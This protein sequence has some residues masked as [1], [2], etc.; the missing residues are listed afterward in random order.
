V[1]V[2]VNG[3]TAVEA[4]E[5]FFVNLSTP[6]N[7]TINDAQATGT[8]QNDDTAPSEPPAVSI[9]DVSHPEGNSGTT[10][11]AFTVSLSHVATG[12][13]SVP[14]ST[15][16]GSAT[17]PSDYTATS[18]T[19][20]FAAGETSKT[21]TVLANGDTGYENDETFTVNLGEPT[22]ATIAD[23]Q[24]TGTI[25]NDDAP[26]SISVDDVSHSEGNSGTTA[27]TFTVSL[28]SPS[29][30]AVTVS[31]ATADG[32]AAAGSDYTTTSGTLT[33]APGEQVKQV[34]VTASGDTL[35]EVNET[36]TLNLSS[37]T[38]GVIGDGTGVGTLV[39]D[40]AEPTLSMRRRRRLRGGHRHGHTRLPG[41]ALR[42]L[43][44]HHHGQL[45]ERRQHG[46]RP[47]RLLEW[48]G[49]SH[50]RARSQFHDDRLA[51]QR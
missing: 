9:A 47:R 17:S 21:I 50:V 20:T 12:S 45:G 18:G 14:Y 35:Y 42:N 11:Y 15:A 34:T 24:A 22:G 44:R 2:L 31:Y 48:A 23:G 40:D 49:N 36:F 3:D 51:G 41:H 38:G 46:N 26:P 25:A 37:P 27:Y 8:I 16:D 19:L 7:A 1:T 28:S 10:V 6:T 30:N 33:F 29:V 4:D 5:R 39:N 13:V 43:G 32:S